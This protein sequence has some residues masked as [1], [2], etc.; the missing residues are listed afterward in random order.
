MDSVQTSFGQV[1]L[2]VLVKLY[3]AQQKHF[4]ARKE[5][6][7]TEE[8]K[9]YNRMKAKEFYARHK[10]EILAKRKALYEVKGDVLNERQKGYYRQRKVETTEA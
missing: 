4:Q 3:E 9:A 1:E 6:L 7:K 8:G 5:W 10:E 2:P